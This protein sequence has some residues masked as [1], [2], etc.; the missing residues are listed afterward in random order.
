MSG[1]K[2]YRLLSEEEIELWRA[3]ARTAI[4]RPGS[5]LPAR[6]RVQSPPPPAPPAKPAIAPAQPTAASY[7]PPMSQPRPALP[8][9]ADLDRRYKQRVTRGRVAI[10]RV[11]DLH[12]LNQAE[13]HGALRG[14]LRSAQM[15]GASLVLVVTGKGM[16]GRGVDSAPE[17]KGILRR[18]V[19]QWLREPDLRTVVLGFEEASQPHG[20][21][22]ALYIRLR[23]KSAHR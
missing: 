21:A 19:P 15:D 2:R 5:S 16:R 3:V 18:A 1:P 13:A 17:E 7:S 14:F 6:T 11:M 22:G 12:G 4:P 9:L 8:P 20:G 10:E 23:R